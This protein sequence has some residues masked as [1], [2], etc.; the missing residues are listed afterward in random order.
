MINMSPVDCSLSLL[1]G[2]MPSDNRCTVQSRRADLYVS[3]SSITYK[4]IHSCLVFVLIRDIFLDLSVTF[5]SR[6]QKTNDC[7]A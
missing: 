5:E 6:L 2:N 1:D 7:I 3:Q 4:N